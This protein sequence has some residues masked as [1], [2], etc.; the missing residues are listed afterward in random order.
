MTKCCTTGIKILKK[1]KKITGKI[2]T[3]KNVHEYL[4]H[5]PIFKE[6]ILSA[7]LREQWPLFS[8]V[9][10]AVLHQDFESLGRV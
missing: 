2:S 1:K 10:T 8:V 3:K 5:A 6:Q 4:V 7:Y 9:F